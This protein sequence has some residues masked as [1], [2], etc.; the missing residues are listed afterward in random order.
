MITEENKE[1]ILINR[2]IRYYYCRQYYTGGCIYLIG[3][4]MLL[5]SIVSPIK[6]L[7]ASVTFSPICDIVYSIK[8]FVENGRIIMKNK[9]LF[10]AS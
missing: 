5:N 2:L 8:S 9:S 4:L 1:L 3:Y 6:T 10:F 7:N